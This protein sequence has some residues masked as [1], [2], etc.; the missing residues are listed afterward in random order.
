MLSFHHVSM[1][2]II[3]TTSEGVV[4]PW[5][6]NKWR[7]QRLAHSKSSINVSCVHCVAVVTTA[8]A[9]LYRV[10]REGLSK[11]TELRPQ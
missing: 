5:W 9:A 2:L 3:V 10:V 1:E 11:E 8:V 7:E 6:V 4:R